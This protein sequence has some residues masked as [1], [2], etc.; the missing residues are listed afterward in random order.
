[1]LAADLHD[2]DA[3]PSELLEWNDTPPS[4]VVYGDVILVQEHR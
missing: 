2:A 3:V 1:M 4:L